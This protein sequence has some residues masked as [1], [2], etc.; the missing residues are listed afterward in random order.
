M[1]NRF[2]SKASTSTAPLSPNSW[3]AHQRKSDI[4]VNNFYEKTNCNTENISAAF[5]PAKSRSPTVLTTPAWRWA[6]GRSNEFFVEAG[7][8]LDHAEHAFAQKVVFS[9][10][11]FKKKFV[12]RPSQR[13]G[14][15]RGNFF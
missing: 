15:C 3:S 10:E 9:D 11:P 13:A 5:A 14:H 1:M 7:I 4:A 2:I 6:S 8:A 12:E